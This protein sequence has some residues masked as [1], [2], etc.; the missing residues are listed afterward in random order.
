VFLVLNEVNWARKGYC[1]ICTLAQRVASFQKCITS[2][3]L[4]RSMSRTLIV[5]QLV[6]KLL[7]FFGTGRFVIM[8]TEHRHRSLSWVTWIHLHIHTPCLISFPILLSHLLH[9]LAAVHFPSI[10]VTKT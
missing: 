8:F 6:N 5:A 1:L 2:C 9:G 3:L 7:A 4:W 10:Y